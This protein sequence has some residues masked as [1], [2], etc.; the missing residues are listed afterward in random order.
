MTSSRAPYRLEIKAAPAM[1]APRPQT[2]APAVGATT[3]DPARATVRMV[4]AAVVTGAAPRL[5]T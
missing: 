4:V 2:S 5:A 3:M 1:L